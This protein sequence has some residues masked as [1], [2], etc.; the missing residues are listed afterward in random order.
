MA[1]L[2]I[3]KKKEGGNREKKRKGDLHSPSKKKEEGEGQK[4]SKM[5]GGEGIRKKDFYPLREEKSDPR[6]LDRL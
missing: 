2:L 6:S 1:S 4:A 3:L 5:G